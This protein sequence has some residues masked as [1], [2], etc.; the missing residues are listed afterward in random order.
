MNFAKVISEAENSSVNKT[1]VWVSSELSNPIIPSLSSKI[2]NI[3]NIIIRLDPREYPRVF[4][5]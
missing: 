1:A 2:T 5:D 3:R 4:V